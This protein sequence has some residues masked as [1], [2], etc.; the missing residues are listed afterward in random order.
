MTKKEATDRAA[1]ILFGSAGELAISAP[2][3][4]ERNSYTIPGDG[5][6]T[7]FAELVSMFLME[8]K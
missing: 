8:Q 6:K 3:G 4:W 1:K 2:A 7:T 5:S